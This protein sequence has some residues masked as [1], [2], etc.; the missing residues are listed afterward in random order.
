MATYS[1]V[2]LAVAEAAGIGGS[3]EAYSSVDNLPTTGNEVGDQAFVSGNNRLYSW[4]GSGWSNIALINTNP[5]FD[6][7]VITY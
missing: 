5:S 1:G 3:T 7:T 2:K 6:S 4:N